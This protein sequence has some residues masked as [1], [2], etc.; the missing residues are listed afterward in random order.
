MRTPTAEVLTAPVEGQQSPG[1][2]LEDLAAAVACAL[3]A[4]ARAGLERPVGHPGRP[5]AQLVGLGDRPPD[6]LDGVREA[7]FEDQ[8]GAVVDEPGLAQDAQVRTR[9]LQTTS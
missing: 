3:D 2:E 1:I 8:G 4:E 7:A 6:A 9:Q 5:V